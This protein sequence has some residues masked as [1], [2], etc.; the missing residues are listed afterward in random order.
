MLEDINNNNN[1]RRS[2]TTP[3]QT[4]TSDQEYK[5]GPGSPPKE[6]QFK[7]G[8]SGN[9]K[10]AK[11]IQ[12]LITG[13][14]SVRPTTLQHAAANAFKSSVQG[15]PALSETKP[16]PQASQY[17]DP[18]S[19]FT[20]PQLPISILPLVVAEFVDA[21][22]QAMG[23]DPSALAMAAVAAVGAALTSETRVQV[24]DGWYERPITNVALVGDPSTMK[25]PV[26]DKATQELRKIDH[27]QDA[28]WRASKAAW[29]QQ[30]ATGNANL[31]PCPPKSPRC[32]IQDAAPEKV[33][34]IL[35]RHPRGSLM[36]HDELAGFLHS[37]DRYGSGPA[38]RAFY[39][40]CFNGG[41]YLKDRVG[42]GARDDNAEIRVENLALSTL[43][44]VQPSR[45]AA[46]TRDL[47]SDGLLQRYL[48]VNMRAALRGNRKHPVAAEEVAF[49]KLVRSVYS[50]L[51]ST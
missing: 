29:Q 10:G 36:V 51:P 33:A 5:V 42:Q 30:K 31:G 27:E 4:G 11:R 1:N 46:T 28:A 43:G 18:Y 44:G 24:G 12:R 20:G 13:D 7:P 23:A 6:Y 22:H 49:A 38:A 2:A 45:L 3:A 8:Q 41:P 47:T 21:E 19:E 16:T 25:S 34:E 39:L 14:E 32:I 15:R 50:A 17:A 26:I 37:F 35:A 9:P 40:T 48:F